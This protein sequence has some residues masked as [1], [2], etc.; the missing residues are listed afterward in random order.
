MKRPPFSGRDPQPLSPPLPRVPRF[1][2][3]CGK[4]GHYRNVCP[5]LPGRLA[6]ERECG[7]R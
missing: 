3:A 4:P 2:K 5:E 7:P 6:T 1:C